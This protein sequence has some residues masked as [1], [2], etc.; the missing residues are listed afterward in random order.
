MFFNVLNNGSKIM[1]QVWKKNKYLW[2]YI[3][4]ALVD[5]AK[6]FGFLSKWVDDKTLILSDVDLG[7]MFD[8]Y[9]YATAAVL[10]MYIARNVMGIGL[11]IKY[12]YS[13]NKI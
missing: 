3:T 10:Q 12:I 5:P 1:L 8:S 7:E 13:K 6:K 11:Q 2:F 9:C 4:S